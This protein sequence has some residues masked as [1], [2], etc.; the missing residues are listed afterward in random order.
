MTGP[1]GAASHHDV[2]V[3]LVQIAVLLAAARAFG[4]IAQH[5]KQ[6][7]VV[8]EIL[9]GI[10]L[11]PSLLGAVAPSLGAWVIPQTPVQGYLLETIALLGVMFLLLITGIETDLPLIRRHAKTAAGASLGGLVLP[12]ATGLLLGWYMPES[13]L[14]ESH[15]RLVFALF[16][17]TAMSI[18]AI[19][20]IAKVL[21]DMDLMRRDV[22]QT[23]LAAG[24]TDDAIGWILLSIVAGLAAGAGV[25]AGGVALAV[26]KVALVM[27]FSFTLGRWMVKRAIDFVQDEVRARDRMLTLVVVLTMLWGALTQALGLEAALGAFLMGMLVGQMP[28]L[29]TEVVHTIESMGLAVFAPVFFAVAGLKVDVLNLLT[30]KLIGIALLVIA[31]ATFGKVGGVYLGARITG[32]RDHWTALSLGA[33][34]NARGAMEIIV[35]TIGLRLGILSQDMFSIIVLM[36][37]VTSLLAPPTLRWA[38]SR[39]TPEDQELDRLRREELAAGSLIANVRR[40]LI[41]VRLRPESD[42]IHRVEAYIVRKM[43][44]R[45]PLSA[46]LLTVSPPEEREASNAF[47]QKLKGE[48][49]PADVTTKVVEGREPEAAI[50]DEAE[51]HYQLML[52]GATDTAPGSG[53]L[54]HPIVDEMVRLAPCSTLVIKGNGGGANW[55]PRRLLVPTNGSVASRHAADV[56]SLLASEANEEVIVLNVAEQRGGLSGYGALAGSATR[57]MDARRR[58]VDELVE[59]GRAYDVAT[60]GTV[61]VG[62]EVD[63]VILETAR[64]ERIDLI[65]VGTDVRPGSDRL[66]LGPRVERILYDAPCPVIVINAG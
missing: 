59:R 30:P 38:L 4:A 1:F 13:L 12:F 36:A 15:Q 57:E 22:G 11:G 27:V 29:P 33:G 8:G 10:L 19:P 60:R 58:F 48:F 31:V 65:V 6:P 5:L 34:M 32:K 24:M 66:F 43:R 47:L 37:M 39:T 41:P 52:L 64:R 42:P 63:S 50:L 44:E 62:S 14:A 2:L 53:S 61:T 40:V 3:L 9:A 55:P 51:K 49:A 45:A 7:S 23:I 16:V 18:S 21:M 35:A 20:V 25:T 46:T 28:R 26:G 17:A 54:F 56:A